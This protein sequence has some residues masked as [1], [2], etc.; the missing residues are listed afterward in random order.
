MLSTKT[1]KVNVRSASEPQ[2]P[3][4]PR[5]TPH[6]LYAQ[7]VVWSLYQVLS[8][9]DGPAL[10]YSGFVPSSQSANMS[11]ATFGGEWLSPRLR[12][13]SEAQGSNVPPVARVASN[14]ASPRTT[15]MV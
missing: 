7:Q 5:P 10:A 1:G 2:R 6:A 11:G 13:R 9:G 4:A 3:N 15:Y 12:F 8:K 14:A